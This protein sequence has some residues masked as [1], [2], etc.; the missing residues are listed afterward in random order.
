MDLVSFILTGQPATDGT[1]P[2]SIATDLSAGEY[3][4]LPSNEKGLET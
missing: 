3:V 2:T 4:I 1:E